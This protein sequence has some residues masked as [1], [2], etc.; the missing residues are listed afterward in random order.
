MTEL[1]APASRIVRNTGFFHHLQ[2]VVVKAM[3]GLF[4]Q[5]GHDAIHEKPRQQGQKYGGSGDDQ[6][7]GYPRFRH[8]R[9]DLPGNADLLQ[10]RNDFRFEFLVYG[11]GV[12]DARD[13]FP[14]KLRK[15]LVG[16]QTVFQG[17]FRLVALGQLLDLVFQQP[18]LGLQSGLVVLLETQQLARL[19]DPLVHLVFP[20][21]K[22]GPVEIAEHQL[23]ALARD[24]LFMLQQLDSGADLFQGDVV[25]VEPGLLGERF[26]I[27][28]F[29]AILADVFHQVRLGL[30]PALLRLLLFP[31]QFLLLLFELALAL[32]DLADIFL[33]I[34]RVEVQRGPHPVQLARQQLGMQT[35]KGRIRSVVFQ[36]HLR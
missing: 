35:R 5:N 9:P 19:G 34:F 10:A 12:E 3:V 28:Q 31:Q 17:F 27:Q 30:V 4:D 18:D 14:V 8:E 15:L 36:E 1:S 7:P 24:L 6:R 33:E 22:L 16:F 21:Q 13:V 23:V 11:E 20:L 25:G 2:D 29:L 32:V 26:R